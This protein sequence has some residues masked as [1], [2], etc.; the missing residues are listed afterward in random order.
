MSEAT[1]TGKLETTPFSQLLVYA[2]DKGLTGSF[3][4]QTPDRQKSALYLVDGAPANAKTG[5]P[6]IHL[7]RLLLEL[8]K[9]D[10]EVY[11]ATLARV[12]KERALHGKLLLDAG[13]IDPPTLDAALAEQ[14][15]RQV[16]WMFA[17]DPRTGYA[18]YEGKNFLDK[19]GG[20][21]VKLEPLGV[22]WRGIRR[23]EN[24]QRVDLA[25]A[26]LG[27]RQLKLHASAQIARFR[28]SDSER[29]VTDVIRAK[30]QTLAELLDAGVA[31]M[32]ETKRLIYTLM[33]TRHL[34]VGAPPLGIG[35]KRS[36]APAPSMR[37]P[38]MAPPPSVRPGP[39][40]APPSPSSPIAAL[41]GSVS[42]PASS[43]TAAPP[44]STRAP[45]SVAPR[46]EPPQ[47]VE[48]RRELRLLDETMPHQNYY[49][50]LGVPVKAAS[51]E[52]S[53]AFFNLA[54]KWHPDR[55]G[56]ELSAVKDDVVR[57]F[58]RMTEA[59][60]V[61]TDDDRRRDYDVL[62][63]DGGGTEA[64]Q[65][66]VNKIMNAV[67]AF[68]KASVYFR[69]GNLAE[70]EVL[71]KQAIDGDPEQAEYR[72][73]WVQCEAQKPAR[74]VKG[75]YSDLIA[76]MDDAVKKEPENER[77][78]MARGDLLKRAG[79]LEQAVA[80]FRWVA[81]H[82]PNNTDAAREVRL[83]AMRGEAKDEKQKG[84]LLGKFF[85]R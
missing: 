41:L 50:M 21:P 17:L 8:G 28:L 62:V 38:A 16:V 61:L 81:R 40:A 10:E 64:E 26:R 37:A 47:L 65:Q 51:P 7:G 74:A 34:D 79:R 70:A 84:G 77:V 27:A 19:W 32:V 68:Q 44:P 67:V 49:E 54:K 13:A 15:L 78:R 59:H 31:D 5:Q 12:A 35:A 3:I 42:L 4:F 45:A 80:D 18:F 73:L 69:K 6:V 39:S 55:L 75:D 85:K 56:P 57:V 25:L 53:A 30:P 20:G 11:N 43:P 82:F 2:L 33:I 23:Y 63:K 72:A 46:S 9:I 60:Q 14:L 76:M 22:I 29:A 52:I 83:F 36:V 24:V 66:E 71:A 58:A 1:A 48:L